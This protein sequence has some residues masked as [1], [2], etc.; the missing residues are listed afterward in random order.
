[1]L[2]IQTSQAKKDG[3]AVSVEREMPERWALVHLNPVL[4]AGNFQSFEE[5]PVVGD[6][7]G[8]RCHVV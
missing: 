1:M 8:F 5:V 4:L 2:I 6:S 7:M 3:I